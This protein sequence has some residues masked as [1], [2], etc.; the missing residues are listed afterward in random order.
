MFVAAT[1]LVPYNIYVNCDPLRVTHCQ[2]EKPTMR[3]MRCRW[4]LYNFESRIESWFCIR[5]CHH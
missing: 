2:N 4:V 1:A 5:L 3:E